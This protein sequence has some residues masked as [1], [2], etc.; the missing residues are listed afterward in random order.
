MGISSGMYYLFIYFFVLSLRKPFCMFSVCFALG[1]AS[2]YL[3]S[4]VLS[5]WLDK[6]FS[7]VPV[8]ILK[9]NLKKTP[10]LNQFI[11]NNFPQI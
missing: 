2:S 7:A 9:L 5:F 4:T 8:Y 3:K 10:I 11:I 6:I 1:K